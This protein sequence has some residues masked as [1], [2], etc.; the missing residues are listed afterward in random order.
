MNHV[1]QIYLSNRY[2]YYYYSFLGEHLILA[3]LIRWRWTK[4]HSDGPVYTD[5]TVPI[6]RGCSYLLD[7][8]TDKVALIRIRNKHWTLLFEDRWALR[9]SS[10]LFIMHCKRVKSTDESWRQKDNKSS[11]DNQRS[12][13]DTKREEWLIDYLY[14]IL[15]YLILITLIWFFKCKFPL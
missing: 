1:Y 2:L 13:P 9:P 14:F 12:C 7:V 15:W 5:S 3:D 6:T 11:R 4:F 10:R 8:S